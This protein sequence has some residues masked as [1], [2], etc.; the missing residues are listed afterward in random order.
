MVKIHLVSGCI[1]QQVI[2]WKA[3]SLFCMCGSCSGG[4]S[5]QGV[6]FDLP[7]SMESKLLNT[8]SITTFAPEKKDSKIMKQDCIRVWNGGNCG[9]SRAGFKTGN[10]KDVHSKGQVFVRAVMLCS[11]LMLFRTSTAY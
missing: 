10:T 2:R 11:Q 5:T 9:L 6:D 8:A 3:P 4:M 1:A 7:S